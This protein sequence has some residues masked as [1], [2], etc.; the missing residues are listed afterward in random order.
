VTDVV[1]V[2]GLWKSYHQRPQI[3]I[4]ELL[5]RRKMVQK[6]RFAREWALQDITFTIKKGCAFGVVGHNGTGKSTLL[7]L[8]LGT[9]VPD[10]GT[11]QVNGRVASLLEIGAGFHPELTGREN[12]FLY[13][14]I[15]GMS[16]RELRQ[17]L[18]MIIEFSELIDAID[19]PIR[20]YSNGMITRLGFSVIAHTPAE[21]L[22]IDEVL[23]VGDAHFQQKCAQKMMQ[24][25]RNQGTIVFVSHDLASLK[26]VCDDGICLN[27]G[28]VARLG[29]IEDVIQHYR[30]ITSA[31]AESFIG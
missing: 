2:R 24:F 16:L 15:L 1:T 26:R 8:L 23:A 21:V 12:I 18:N 29:S 31:P 7:G 17:Q 28:K 30:E 10:Q 9:M 4:K 3:G 20:T 11:I 22:L 14:S 19:N 25:K 27:E 5:V 13:G 6:G